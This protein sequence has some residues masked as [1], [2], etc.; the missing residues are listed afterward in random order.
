MKNENAPK[1]EI[2]QRFVSP[3][4]TARLFSDLEVHWRKDYFGIEVAFLAS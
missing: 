1:T 2:P 3:A 4:I